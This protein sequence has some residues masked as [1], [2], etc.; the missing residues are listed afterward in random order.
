MTQVRRTKIVVT[1]GPA[2]E[3]EAVLR[4]IIEAGADVLRLNFSHGDHAEHAQRIALAR[5]LAGEAGRVVAILQDLQGPKIRIGALARG[6]VQLRQ[7]ARFVITTRQVA[8]TRERVSTTYTGLPSD[9]R[10]GDPILL[11]DCLIELQVTRV[12]RNEVECT[13]IRG[14]T[15]L[16]HKGVNLP[17]VKVS[18]PALTEKDR[19][20]LRFGLS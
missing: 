17:G 10:P 7:G 15:L 3:D 20:D 19:A 12:R 8:G 11:N 9:V 6:A 14:G 5:R 1:L 13:V 18:A 2:T 16:P 4:R